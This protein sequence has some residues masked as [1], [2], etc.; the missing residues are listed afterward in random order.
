MHDQE[1]CCLPGQWNP[2]PAPKFEGESLTGE[3]VTC[4]SDE[5]PWKPF[6]P[7]S[8]LNRLEATGRSEEDVERMK[9]WQ[10]LQ[11]ELPLLGQM[12]PMRQNRLLKLFGRNR[13]AH[14]RHGPGEE[15]Y[16][17]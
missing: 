8:E 1:D 7:E 17:Y 10:Q 6:N 5:Q 16:I 13:Q 15:A 14:E 11:S 3:W 4:E 2:G 12:E 9:A